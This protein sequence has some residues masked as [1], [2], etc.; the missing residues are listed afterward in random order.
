MAGAGC[1]RCGGDTFSISVS[2]SATGD[3]SG[4]GTK[5]TCKAC[6]HLLTMEEFKR[7]QGESKP[8]EKPVKKA[9]AKKAAKKTGD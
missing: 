7:T 2:L 5:I 3:V 9:P 4:S 8:A 1:P 6:G